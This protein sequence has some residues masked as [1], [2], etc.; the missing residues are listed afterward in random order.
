MNLVDM[1]LQRLRSCRGQ[2][3]ISA[4]SKHAW[5]LSLKLAVF[6]ELRFKRLGPKTFVQ[7][8]RLPPALLRKTFS[9]AHHLTI[10]GKEVH[11]EQ[12]CFRKIQLSAPT[13][14]RSRS[15]GSTKIEIALARA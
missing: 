8:A 5:W 9:S 2:P 15:S 3:G 10:E 12:F 4:A 14:R 1:P 7:P 6:G 13:E 11:L